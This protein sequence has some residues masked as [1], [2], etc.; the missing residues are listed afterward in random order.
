MKLFYGTGY[1]NVQEKYKNIKKNKP[2]HRISEKEGRGTPRQFEL[3]E[4]SDF[5]KQT[6]KTY[7]YILSLTFDIFE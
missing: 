5:S 3:Y 6:K 4:K 1:L 2:I 7:R